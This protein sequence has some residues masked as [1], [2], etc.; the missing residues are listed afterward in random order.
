MASKI[1][2]YGLIGNTR[3]AAL[4]SRSGSI[5]W[6]CA[7]RFD[8]DACFAALVGYD[9]HGR[10]A[11]APDGARAR[12][13]A[14]LSRR[15]AG[16]GDRVRSATAASSASPTSCRS[17]ERLRRRPHH[18][19]RRRARCR[20]RCCSTSASA[21]APTAPLD[22]DDGA[23][24]R[25]FMAGPDALILRGPL[26]LTQVERPRRRRMLH[27]QEGRSH[28]AAAHLVP[29]ARAAARRRSTSSRRWRRP[30]RSGGSGRAAAPTRAAG[31]TPSCARCSRS[32]R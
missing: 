10:W 12:D 18:R 16:A 11:L 25:C 31:A 13:A 27:G 15:H 17:R 32:R 19:G 14:A 28:P 3:T 24:G 5:D 30:R 2:D 23:T 26:S 29:V 21:T 4:V 6:L 8:S 7:P 22:R 1:E 9:E 20:W